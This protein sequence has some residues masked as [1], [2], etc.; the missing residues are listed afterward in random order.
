M[1]RLAILQEQAVKV[2]GVFLSEIK[3]SL[4]AKS[5]ED[6][7]TPAALKLPDHCHTRFR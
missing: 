6:S 5:V 3:L 2:G 1:T 4:V 7:V